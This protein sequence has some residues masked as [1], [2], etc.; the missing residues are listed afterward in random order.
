MSN[1]REVATDLMTTVEFAIKSGDWKVDGACDPT[2][3]IIRLKNI[4]AKPQ[5]QWVGL[6]DEEIKEYEWMGRDVIAVIK[7]VQATLKEKNT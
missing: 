4:L 2:V 1:L 6:T 3:D 5:P 7:E